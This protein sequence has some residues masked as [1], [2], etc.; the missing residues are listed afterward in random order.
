MKKKFITKR[1]NYFINYK[2]LFIIIFY[3]I[4]VYIGFRYLNNRSSVDD[5]KIVQILLS[6]SNHHNKHKNNMINKLVSKVSI[7]NSVMLI[8]SNYNK[9]VDNKGNVQKDDSINRNKDNPMIYIY[10]THQKEEYASSSYVEY[11]V[12]P[13]VQMANYILE[14]IFNKNGLKTFVEEN[15]V[16]DILNAHK[17]NYSYSYLASRSLMEN[18]KQSNPSLKYFIDIHRDSLVKDKTTIQINNKNYASILFIVGLENQNYKDNLA[19]TN[20][21]NNVINNKYPTLSKGIYKK[22]GRGVNGVYNQ[23]FSS[24]T[25]LI[26]IG[27]KDNT[28]EEVLNTS[29][30]FAE[31]FM[32]VL[33]NNEG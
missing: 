28:I 6:T 10:N 27:G 31:C 13:T 24:N 7:N 25:I 16:K 29:L 19:F 23:D 4:G 26:E 22:G 3:C 8:N 1:K 30:A 11:S 21:I 14:D 15:S 20:K 12:K 32:E 9:L 33:S 18:A 2:F 5:K 17:W